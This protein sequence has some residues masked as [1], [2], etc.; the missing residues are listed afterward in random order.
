MGINRF[1]TIDA[2]DVLFFQFISIVLC[3]A[4]GE[5]FT[6]GQALKATTRSI[7][8]LRQMYSFSF[9]VGGSKEIVTRSSWT[10]IFMKRLKGEG[11]NCGALMPIS[12]VS[13]LFDNRSNQIISFIST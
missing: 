2:Q 9:E 13:N 10:G 5:V 11:V 1:P 3:Q 12:F 7:S 6:C 4:R 8:A